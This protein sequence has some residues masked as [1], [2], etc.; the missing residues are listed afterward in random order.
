MLRVFFHLFKKIQS[1]ALGQQEY[2]AKL[3]LRPAGCA[4]AGGALQCWRDA[5]VSSTMWS[6]KAP[7]ASA[8]RGRGVP[9]LTQMDV[10]KETLTKRS[11][12]PLNARETPATSPSPPQSPIPSSSV[13]RR[14]PQRFS[15]LYGRVPKPPTFIWA[16]LVLSQRGQSELPG[17]GRVTDPTGTSSSSCTGPACPPWPS[18]SSVG[19]IT[20]ARCLR[21]GGW[22]GAG[23]ACASSPAPRA[24]P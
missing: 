9:C 2:V 11:G 10:C 8:G 23:C 24:L 21:R 12:N 3:L 16:G 7:A 6:W 1:K 20:A 15:P 22:R 13:Q 14:R 17:K 19:V 5:A 4:Q 18:G